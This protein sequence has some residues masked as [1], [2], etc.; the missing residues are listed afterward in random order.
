VGVV[1]VPLFKAAG[2]VSA[3]A[4]AIATA[5]AVGLMLVVGFAPLASH[6]SVGATAD[7]ATGQVVQQPE[8]TTTSSLVADDG[9]WVLIP[10]AIPLVITLLV[11]VSLA[12]GW[13]LAGWALTLLLAAFTALAVLSIGNFVLP[14][15][16][17]LILAC[18][19]ARGRSSRVA[20]AEPLPG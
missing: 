5:L 9:V 3:W 10:L 17:T 16:L 15:T 12:Y 2:R 20:T 8:V 13:R 11:G 1:H 18:A 19:T 6:S 7:S 14:I 4:L